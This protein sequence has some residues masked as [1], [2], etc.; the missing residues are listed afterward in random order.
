[1]NRLGL[2]LLDVSVAL[3][4]FAN[5]ILGI[6]GKTVSFLGISVGG[7]EFGKMLQTLS[8]NPAKGFGHFLLIVLSVCAIAAGVFLLLALFQI[9]IP[10]TDLILLIFICLWVVFIVVVD[11]I[12]PLQSNKNSDFLQYLLQL[13]PHLMVLGA[14]ITSTKRFGN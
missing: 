9:E 4:L 12:N 13:S 6:T 10:I 2:I 14:L 3:Y 8:I 5:G 7:G 11:I 1:M